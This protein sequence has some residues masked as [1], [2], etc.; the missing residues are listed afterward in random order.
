MEE[1]VMALMAGA[2]LALSG[3]VLQR[4][5]KRERLKLLREAAPE[6]K[7]ALGKRELLEWRRDNLRRGA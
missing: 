2:L 6:I 4:G 7:W 3:V 5:V 1:F